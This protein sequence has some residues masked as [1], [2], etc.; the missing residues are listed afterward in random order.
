VQRL[1]RLLTEIA[2]TV[3]LSRTATVD[4][5][6]RA[7]VEETYFGRHS[8]GIDAAKKAYYGCA[9]SPL[10]IAQVALLVGLPQNPSNLDPVVH[11][12]RAMARRKY[13]LQA[14]ASARVISD[15]EAAKAVAENT[16]STVVPSALECP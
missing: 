2:V 10:T 14:L 5:L 9:A 1:R 6:K 7:L 4:A 12:D 3:W 15:V 11:S 16:E 8:Y 13:V